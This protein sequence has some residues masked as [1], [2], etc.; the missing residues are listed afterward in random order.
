MSFVTALV[1]NIRGVPCGVLEM[2]M[3]KG[4][5]SDNLTAEQRAKLDDD[6]AEYTDSLFGESKEPKE[7]KKD[8]KAKPQV[9]AAPPTVI[10]REYL[11]TLTVPKLREV[12]K[13]C[14]A[15]KGRK[16]RAEIITLLVEYFGTAP[17][18]EGSEDELHPEPV[19]VITKVKKAKAEVKEPKAKAP[20]KPKGKKEAKEAKEEAKEDEEPAVTVRSW[21][22]PDE[23]DKPVSE[24]TKYYIDPL[25]N[26]LYD[27][28]NPDEPI[29]KWD[30]EEQ[31]IIPLM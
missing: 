20:K 8:K 17:A 31:E 19:P 28:E 11:E 13:E 5:V 23:M 21:Y 18:E 2:L 30:D 10:T 14:A 29:G 6:M 9:A 4:W 12:G 25:T 24:R 22:R 26:N 1:E 3:S 15:I 27:P 16:P 7:V